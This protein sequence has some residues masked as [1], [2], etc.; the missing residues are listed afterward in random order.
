MKNKLLLLLFS[1]V[2]VLFSCNSSES[3]S[4]KTIS[5]SIENQDS[6]NKILI[7]IAAKQ[8]T[9]QL[10]SVFKFRLKTT[11]L[12]ACVLVAQEGQVLYENAMGFSD[13]KN[14]ETLKIN[15]EF[16]LASTSKTFTAAAILIL[17]DEGK[18]NLSDSVQ[19]FF[20]DFPYHNITVKM[21]LTHRSGLFN[22]VYNCEP[23]CEK[24]DLYNNQIFDNK[25]MLDIIVHHKQGVYC[26]PNKKFEYCNTNY[27]L[28]ALIVEKVSG[29]PFS[30]FMQQNIFK[31]LGMKNTWIYNKNEESIHKNK[32]IGHNALGR[33]E[34][35]EFADDVVGDKGVYSTVEDLFKWD[36]ALYSEKILKKETLEEA[37]T[38]YSNEHKG[39]RNYGFGW[40][41]TDDGKN[42]KII[43][44]NGWWH[45]YNSLFFRRPSD[46]TTIIILS[47]KYNAS[48]YHIDDVLSVLS[49]NA[50]ATIDGEE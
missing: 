46:R 37:F 15:S 9:H 19:Q 8:K 11:H 43:Y 29:M 48:I 23:Y 12:N 18:L 27:A 16:Q 30:E 32:T 26:A 33:K 13:V 20:P 1:F 10:D 35:D 31:P 24:P 21:L 5:V 50:N 45:G 39:K 4:S 34:V 7:K 22:Y 42:P 17:R 41:I 25:A 3:N 47:N 6:I 40:R 44:H 38:G 49:K 36:Q 2:L 14:K 28:L